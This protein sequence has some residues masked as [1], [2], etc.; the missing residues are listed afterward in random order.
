MR[1]CDVLKCK[2]THKPKYYL[3]YSTGDSKRPIQAYF[4]CEDCSNNP[5]YNDS[6]SI[7]HMEELREGTRI[8]V[9]NLKEL[10]FPDDFPVDFFKDKRGIYL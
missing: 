3:L 10:K 6:N 8:T 5:I 2:N 9:P 4:V 7:I 1:E